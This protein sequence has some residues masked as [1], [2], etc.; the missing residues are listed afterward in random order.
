VRDCAFPDLIPSRPGDREA[1]GV[2]GRRLCWRRPRSGFPCGPTGASGSGFSLIFPGHAPQPEAHAC[3][4]GCDWLVRPCVSI[5]PVLRE[6]HS[7]VS[8]AARS[9]PCTTRVTR[10]VAS[11]IAPSIFPE[12]HKLSAGFLP[13]A[14]LAM[15]RW[16]TGPNG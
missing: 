2:Q 15:T 8:F 12:R 7:R 14:I 4:G 11:P 9:I 10:L 3:E 6:M 16:I 5:P 1:G 13:V